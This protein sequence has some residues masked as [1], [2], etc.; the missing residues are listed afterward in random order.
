MRYVPAAIVWLDVV[1]VNVAAALVVTLA[2]SDTDAL[3]AVPVETYPAVTTGVIDID[4]VSVS[5]FVPVDTDADEPVTVVGPLAV[6]AD[7]AFVA[8]DA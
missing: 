4:L 5:V 7:T 2:V 1:G 8:L 3:C 6:P